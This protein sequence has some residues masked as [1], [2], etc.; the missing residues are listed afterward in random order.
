MNAPAPVA[1]AMFHDA[2][3]ERLRLRVRGAVQ[4]VGFR[5]FAYAL[6]QRYGLGGFVLNDSEGVL[7]EI[8]GARTGDFLASLASEQ[9]RLARIDFVE[10]DSIAPL[11]E[12]AFAIAR[13]SFWRGRDA[14]R[15]GYGDVPR[16]PRRPLQSAKPFSPLSLRQL[17]SLRTAPQHR[18]G[19]P[20]RPRRDDDGAVPALPVLRRR[21]RD[22]ADRRFHAEAIACAECGPR[23]R[24]LRLADGAEAGA[25]AARSTPRRR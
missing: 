15:G 9:P 16:M 22:P 6:A 7:I 18:H 1:E 2:R 23:A 25:G 20:L 13:E 4:G 11:G 17:C 14:R 12:R 21:L 5:P 3:F 24:L 8:K 19:D 10:A